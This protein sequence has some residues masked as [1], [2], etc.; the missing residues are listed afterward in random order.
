MSLSINQSLGA[1]AAAGAL[2]ILGWQANES[3]GPGPRPQYTQGSPEVQK[4]VNALI[5]VAEQACL[6]SGTIDGENWT[7][8]RY[9]LLREKA[10]TVRVLCQQIRSQKDRVFT[11]QIG[12]ESRSTRDGQLYTPAAKIPAP[13]N[14][15]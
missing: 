11:V 12:D 13:R 5:G 7:R 3:R 8:K 10:G 6:T 14:I 4:Q 9:D 1:I 15:D 2:S